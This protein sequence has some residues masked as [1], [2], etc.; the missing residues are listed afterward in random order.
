MS[1]LDIKQFIQKTHPFEILSADELK[2]LLD[3]I[4]IQYFKQNEIIATKNSTPKYFYIIAKGV[5]EQKD[6]E[7]VYYSVHD[8]FDIT[9][10]FQN[11]F[12]NDFLA[13][14]ES[15]CYLIPID[16]FYMLLNQNISFKSFFLDDI[17]TKINAL[18]HKNANKELSNFMLAKVSES[19]IHPL[20]IIDKDSSIYDGV[21][22]MTQNSTSFIIVDFQNS[23]GI[24]TDSD[25]RKKVILQNKS[26]QDKI[27]SIATKELITIDKNDFLFN[28]LLLMTQKN[29]K[30]L[31]VTKDNSIFGIIE[32]AD[33]LSAFS[34]KSHL[35][36][37][38]IQKAK[39]VSDIQKASCDII[40]LVKSLHVKGVKVRYITKLLSEINSK[41]YQ[42]IYEIIA[43]KEL[44]E[45]SCFIILGSEGRHEQI[46][47]SDQDNGIILK[48]GFVFDKLSEV[49]NSIT[50]A[51]LLCGF[52]KC[53]G[54]I[55]VN[56]P[57]W[58][59]SLSEYKNSVH[60]WFNSNSSEDLMN[61]AILFDAKC[62]AGDSKLLDS[63]KEYM[64]NQIN[65]NLTLLSNFAKAT[66]IFETPL[67]FFSNFILNKKSDELDLKKG[68][69]FPIVHGIRSLALEKKII[70]TNTIERVKE[71]N[72]LGV[73]DR[74][75]ASNLI[76]GFNF[77][78]TIRLENMLKKHD[79]GLKLDS[80]INPKNLSKLEKDTLI[81]VFKMV[82]KFKK[83]IIHH[84]K[85]SMIS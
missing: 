54:N 22:K 36:N 6:E 66:I 25:L 44:L 10:I 78:L 12:K 26:Y 70:A 80:G 65:D 8:S 58:T 15:I 56:N 13:F 60:D 39:T 75:F 33:I 42:K 51:L 76:D 81:D 84:F 24:V 77:L 69:I 32:Q 47:K 4:D 14:E 83:L 5:V 50:E 79:L 37:I 21:Q 28:A 71:L 52:P 40:N 30:R 46:L 7:S 74:E 68:A 45:N 61:L 59:K 2:Y 85:L 20:V 1:T 62:V 35:I 63:L 48:D 57:F 55:M 64:F 16:I 67:S 53:E 17:S 72:N 34:N 31:I 38:Q 3:S 19:Y 41:I 23:Y 9:S 11:S 49:T 82:D 43:P 18:I 29:L 73:F 27:S